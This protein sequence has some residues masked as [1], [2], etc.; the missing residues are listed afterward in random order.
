MEHRRE[1]VQTQKPGNL[2]AE[3]PPEPPRPLQSPHRS[4]SPERHGPSLPGIP[5]P[6]RSGERGS[7][8][9]SG[10]RIGGGGLMN[11]VL[12]ESS[13]VGQALSNR[14]NIV[15]VYTKHKNRHFV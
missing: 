8:Q 13:I 4:G 10:E 1:M 7:D 11:P 6:G 12:D 9:S 15:N 2:L 5:H 3:R 14:G